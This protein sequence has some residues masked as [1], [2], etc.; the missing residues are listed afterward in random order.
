MCHNCHCDTNDRIYP[1]WKPQGTM[2]CV[3]CFDNYMVNPLPEGITS[4][5]EHISSI[6]TD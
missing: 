3:S 1:Q 6:S 4:I 2:W 5:E